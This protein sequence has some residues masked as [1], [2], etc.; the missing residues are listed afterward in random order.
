M[1]RQ[2][3]HPNVCRVYDVGESG[4]RLFLSMEF[5]DGEGLASL[6]RRIGRIRRPSHLVATGLQQNR[7]AKL[8]INRPSLALWM[9]TSKCNS[10]ATGELSEAL[11]PK[12][13][14]HRRS[15]PATRDGARAGKPL[16]RDLRSLPRGARA[17]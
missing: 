6:L 5:V 15:H 11:H 7:V 12:L 9:H 10:V 13:C 2:V 4:S 1:A 3:S 8:D 17:A 14:A 16:H